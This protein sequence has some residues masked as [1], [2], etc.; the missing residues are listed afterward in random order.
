VCFWLNA[1][2]F[3]KIGSPRCSHS[4]SSQGCSHSSTTFRT[5]TRSHGC[6]RT[7]QGR[8]LNPLSC[9]GS[10]ICYRGRFYHNFFILCCFFALFPS[11][12]KIYLASVI[13][14]GVPSEPPFA[15][16]ET[17]SVPPPLLTQQ[18]VVCKRGS[19]RCSHARSSQGCTHSSTT[20]RTSTRTHGCHRTGQLL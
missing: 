6:H 14:E 15:V 9:Q 10:S 7:G 8:T 11:S 20:D 5:S 17:P 2:S 4:R 12:W 3:D 16:G 1:P 13:S 18:Q 19:P